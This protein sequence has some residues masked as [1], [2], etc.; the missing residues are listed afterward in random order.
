MSV[1]SNLTGADLHESKGV[2]TAA[3]GTVYVAN[4]VGSGAWTPASSIITNTAFS[5]GD[6]KIG[7]KFIADTG[8]I[9]LDEGAIGDGSSGASSR[10][11]ADCSALFQLFWNNCSNTD[12][13]VSGG[14][15]GSAAADFAAHKTIGLPKV[16]S[17]FIVMAGSGAAL[18]AYS[19]GDKG[20]A[21]T[22][23][24]VTG[25][26]PA[27]TPVGTNA[28]TVTNGTFGA[29]LSLFSGGGTQGF[30]TGSSPTTTLFAPT[31][32]ISITSAF[33]GTAQGGVST[34]V[35]IRPPFAAMYAMV[36]L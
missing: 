11:N 5:T 34:P 14:R 31:T 19:G 28:I 35:N 20:G 12:C 36:K 9:M 15:G 3:N 8:W 17:R 16:Q 27:Y 29:P 24:L 7:Y 4:G 32:G 21:E 23:V 22:V 25:N 26:L 30:T 1:H 13:P 2:A 18:S 10:A 6:V 33:T